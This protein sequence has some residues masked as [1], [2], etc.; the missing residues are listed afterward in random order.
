MPPPGER[1]PSAGEGRRASTEQHGVEQPCA[2]V[3]DPVMVTRLLLQK[4][5]RIEALGVVFFLA[6][7][8]GRLGERALR[9][10][11]ETTGST[12][13]GGAYKGRF[14]EK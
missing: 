2:F 1:A 12:G 5:E 8:L 6:L 9:V 14:F 3:K 4:P 7:R 10:H 11:V 13:T